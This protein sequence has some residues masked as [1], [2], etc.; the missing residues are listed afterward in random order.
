MGRT[1]TK[2]SMSLKT[3]ITLGI[4][5]GDFLKGFFN[6][7]FFHKVCC[8]SYPLVEGVLYCSKPM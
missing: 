8:K 5:W 2:E 4:S 6:S 1:L 7:L 3:P